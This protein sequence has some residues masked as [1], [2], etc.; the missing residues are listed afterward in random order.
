M[1]GG[2]NRGGIGFGVG[3]GFCVE[4]CLGKHV[5]FW[6]SCE[7]SLPNLGFSAFCSFIGRRKFCWFSNG[8]PNFVFFRSVSERVFKNLANVQN[9]GKSRLK[10]F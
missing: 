8:F 4:I 2:I 1:Y 10:D 3:K 5:C 7:V 9:C 6:I